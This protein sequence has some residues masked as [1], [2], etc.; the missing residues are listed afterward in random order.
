MTALDI[1]FQDRHVIVVNK[2]ARIPVGSDDSKDET[3]L[4]IVRRWNVARQVEGKKGYCVPVHF[5]DRPVSGVVVFAL[6]S[7]AAERLATAFKG[8]TV[9]KRYLAVVEGEP[10]HTEGRLKHFLVKDHERNVTRIGRDTESG[11]KEARLSYKVI[12][13]RGNLTLVLVRPE[14]GRSHQIRVQLSSLGTPIYGDLRYGASTAW[15]GRIA[16]HAT[17]LLFP[18][19]VEAVPTT[20]TADLPDYWDE[21]WQGINKEVD[22]KATLKAIS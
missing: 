5:L 15:E 14:T 1:L 9:E 16:L 19:P 3:L 21:L 18:H 6:S 10:K 7:K 4:E 17:Q 11:A 2:A 22:V 12:A 8:R 20:I 13:R